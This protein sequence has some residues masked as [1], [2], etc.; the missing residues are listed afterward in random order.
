MS[1]VKAH[2]ERHRL[3]ASQD[4]MRA[5]IEWCIAETPNLNKIRLVESVRS[6]WLD[7]DI[8]TEG[9]QSGPQLL[10]SDLDAKALT[11]TPI[12]DTLVLQVLK[13]VDIS[14]PAYAQLETL[15]KTTENLAN[16]EVNSERT[17]VKSWAPPPTARTLKM[18][19]T[20]GFRTVDALEFQPCP[21]L[22]DPVPC[23]LKLALKGP[24]AVRRGL[25]LLRPGNLKVLGGLVEDLEAEGGL[26]SALK[27]RLEGGGGEGHPPGGGGNGLPTQKY[28]R[29]P[30]ADSLIKYKKAAPKAVKKEVGRKTM[31]TAAAAKKEN[32]P[33][34]D[35]DDDDEDLFKGI[36]DRDLGLASTVAAPKVDLG[37]LDDDD[38]FNDIEMPDDLPS[39]ISTFKGHQ[40]SKTKKLKAEP[41]TTHDSKKAKN[42]AATE[43]QH[44]REPYKKAKRALNHKQEQQQPWKE[45]DAA[46]AEDTEP[47]KRPRRSFD[48]R[49]VAGRPYQYLS[50]LLDNGDLSSQGPLTIKGCIVTL[51][52]KLT[53]ESSTS[54]STK[55]SSSK[56]WSLTVVVTDGSATL[57]VRLAPTLL[58][59]W[60]EATP[61]QFAAMEQGQKAVV[62]ANMK[63]L[64]DKLLNMNG[65]FKLDPR[66][67]ELTEVISLNRG[68][69]QQLKVRNA[70]L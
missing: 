47:Q 65:L 41:S 50:T 31:K 57:K 43:E 19:L 34:S 62:K 18:T 30:N 42:P 39:T 66:T 17:Q 20:D 29:P 52:G 4:W 2:F 67:N 14:K 48:A 51:A 13:A 44:N 40:N 21:D 49:A 59:N 23:G 15:E 25:L 22:P 1:L 53:A 11:S 10:K 45:E 36:S 61:A 63:N 69:A 60:F 9:V 46:F 54:R 5:C 6:Q 58:N 38:M 35:G 28:K 24:I 26:K 55:G 27:E 56:Q 70:K 64:S 3:H 37:D 7:T 12:D 16:L 33:F 8:R 32:N 68:H